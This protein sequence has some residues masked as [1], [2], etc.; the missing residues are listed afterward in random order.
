[1]AFCR[2]IKALIPVSLIFEIEKDV[3]C[4]FLIIGANGARFFYARP[5][6]VF[7][8]KSN[9]KFKLRRL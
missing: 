2:E 3:F 7:T 6:T 8:G 9:M 4:N 1:M 5:K